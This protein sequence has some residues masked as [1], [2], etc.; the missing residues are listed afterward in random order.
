MP[1]PE[2][3]TTT[4]TTDPTTDLAADKKPKAEL[5][6]K[7][8]QTG[9]QWNDNTYYSGVVIAKREANSLSINS[10]GPI[11]ILEVTDKNPAVNGKIVRTFE[12]P[13][14]EI[15]PGNPGDQTQR[16]WFKIER[17]MRPDRVRIEVATGLRLTPP[18]E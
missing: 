5:L 17:M 10:V 8:E 9:R 14:K 18:E 2:T 11:W 6:P 7:D 16:F 12:D 1:D 15:Q 13:G 3:N 4:T